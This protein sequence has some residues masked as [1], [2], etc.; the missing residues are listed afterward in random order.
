MPATTE[1][2]PESPEAL[3][4]D[5]NNRRALIAFLEEH[6]SREENRNDPRTRL[7]LDT[8]ILGLSGQEEHRIRVPRELSVIMDGVR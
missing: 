2:A 5:T 8:M 6:A 4:P 1:R 7:L 3:E